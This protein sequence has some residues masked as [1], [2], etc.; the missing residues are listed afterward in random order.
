MANIIM[1][2][3]KYLKFNFVLFMEYQ[4]VV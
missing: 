1:V 4:G 2:K 3:E